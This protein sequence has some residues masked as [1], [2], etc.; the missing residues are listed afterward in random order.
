ME[1]E[2]ILTVTINCKVETTKLVYDPSLHRRNESVE[3]I[4]WKV[5]KKLSSEMAGTA[6]ASKDQI[7]VTL[8]FKKL[9]GYQPLPII[10]S[11]IENSE[12]ILLVCFNEQI[13][14][15]VK[16]ELELRG[17]ICEVGK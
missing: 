8:T 11:P 12:K 9:K 2:E 13:S 17:Y 15:L 4:E 5:I 1:T 6:L 10:V 3:K 16:S 14:T 7:S